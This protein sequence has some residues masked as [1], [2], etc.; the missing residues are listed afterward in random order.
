MRICVFTYDHPHDKTAKGLAAMWL[1]GFNPSVIW[2][3]PWKDIHKHFNFNYHPS[4][5]AKR[6]GCSYVVSSHKVPIEH[7]CD[8]GVILGAKILPKSVIDSFPLGVINIHPG[9]LPKSAGLKAY[10]LEWACNEGILT[11]HLIDEHIDQ[12]EFILEREVP[13]LPHDTYEAF[14]ARM[15]AEQM[16]LLIEA[17]RMVSE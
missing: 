7:G 3:N 9:R 15:N 16:P 2:A 12:G 4:L 11:A 14:V 5:Y 1:N 17:I 13:K 8:L 6:F 10:E